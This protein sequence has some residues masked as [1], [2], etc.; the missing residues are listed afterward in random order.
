M[1]AKRVS[2][3]EGKRDFTQLLKEAREKQMPILI[4]NE[5]EDEFA[6]AILSPQEYE[7]Y[8][9]LNACFEALRLSKK[10]EHLALNVP[11]LVRRSRQEL[12]ERAS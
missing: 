11:E 12:E 7:R 10:F 1:T 2:V 3:A 5:R 4:F 6:G 9:K 8:E